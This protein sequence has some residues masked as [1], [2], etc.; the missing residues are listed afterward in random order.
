MSTA[1]GK[2]ELE[3]NRH[4]FLDHECCSLKRDWPGL[5]KI[6]YRGVSISFSVSDTE[7]LLEIVSSSET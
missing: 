7:L 3:G 2:V 4:E 5:A 1:N 6:S